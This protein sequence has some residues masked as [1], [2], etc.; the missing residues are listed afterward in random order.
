M[1]LGRGGTS[2]FVVLVTLCVTHFLARLKSPLSRRC[3]PKEGFVVERKRARR[4]SAV[5]DSMDR[6][7]AVVCRGKE[8]PIRQLCAVK[9]KL[10]VKQHKIRLQTES[11]SLSIL[12]FSSI[13]ISSVSQY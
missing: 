1:K 13:F 5:S 9:L 12:R 2:G 4:R 7:C 8:L 6:F 3:E 11:N 10:L